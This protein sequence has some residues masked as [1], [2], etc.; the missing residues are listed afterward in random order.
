MKPCTDLAGITAMV[1]TGDG[2]VLLIDEDGWV[3]DGD[4]GYPPD[5]ARTLS[6]ALLAA[7]EKAEEGTR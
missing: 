6:A 3:I 7:A 4:T 1:P 5:E 2:S